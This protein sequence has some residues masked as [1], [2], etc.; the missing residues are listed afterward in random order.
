MGQSIYL[1]IHL[2][3]YIISIPSPPELLR[4]FPNSNVVSVEWPAGTSWWLPSYYNAVARV[5]S[6]AQDLTALLHNLTSSCHLDLRDL[7]LIGHSL[8]AHVAGL[9]A[10]PLDTV[11]RIS[12][13]CPSMC[14]YWPGVGKDRYI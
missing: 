4:V 10:A 6:V 1:S 13:K 2:S 9:A 14:V 7:H 12:G 8:G 3:I 5:P 11:G